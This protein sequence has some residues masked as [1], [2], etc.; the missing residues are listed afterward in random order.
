MRPSAAALAS[1]SRGSGPVRHRGPWGPFRVVAIGLANVAT[2]CGGLLSP[3]GRVN[4]RLHVAANS[5][6][7]QRNPLRRAPRLADW[8]CETR[9]EF[10]ASRRPASGQLMRQVKTLTTKPLT[11]RSWPSAT[12][13]SRRSR[14][15]S[16]RPRTRT[17]AAT[18]SRT[19]T[20]AAVG[21]ADRRTGQLFSLRLSAARGRHAVRGQCRSRRLPLERRT[22]A[23]P[24]RHQGTRGG[25]RPS[26]ADA[27]WCFWS[28]CPAR[29][30]RPTSCRWSKSR[31]GCWSSNWARTTAWRSWS[32]PAARAWCLPSTCGTR[33]GRPSCGARRAARPAA[34]PTAR[35]GIQLAYDIAV[36]NFI[37]GGVNR[38]ILAT[39][40]DFN[41]GVT[42]RGELI[43]LIEAKGQERRVP[44]RARLRHGQPQGR[45]AR[46]TGRQGERQLRLHRHPRAR[47]T[48]CSSSRCPAR[49]S[50]SPRT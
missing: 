22:S 45:H 39:D 21:R 49:W 10:V 13:R 48:R 25:P 6:R 8:Q 47:P 31:C 37:K 41:V 36:A 33:Q 26:A 46:A 35:Q 3:L 32:M 19:A 4:T 24:H 2:E 42:D 9:V 43:R 44:D 38:V 1:R 40:G 12:I 14:S 7:T 30:S 18:C 34:R 15:M 50:R 11:T 29:C 16:I 5:G 27:T 28:T 23:G 17:S 20:A